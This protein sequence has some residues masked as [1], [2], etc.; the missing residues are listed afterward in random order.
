MSGVDVTNMSGSPGGGGSRI[1]IRG[2]SSLNQQGI[3]DGSPLFV[4]D[5]I[6]VSS[7]SSTLTGGINPLSSLDPSSIESVQVLKD[8]T[9]I[10]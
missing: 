3:N 2:F 4:I 1:T 9:D 6:P 7:S 10:V 5:G 8:L